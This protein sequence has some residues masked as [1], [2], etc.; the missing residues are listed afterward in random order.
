[1]GSNRDTKQLLDLA[2]CADIVCPV[3][4]LLSANPQ[5]IVEDPFNYAGAFD[6]AGYTTINMLRS[7]GLP[8]VI[9]L[10]QHIEKIEPKHQDKIIKFYK[11]FLTS[12]FNESKS[13]TLQSNNDIVN[14][15]RTL[16]SCGLVAQSWKT[17]RGY[18]LADQAEV[19]A[20]GNVTVFG[21]LKGSCINPNQLVHVTGLDDFQIEKI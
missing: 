8:R 15:F 14:L 17:D 7:L 1:V 19:N 10:I 3:V 4:S 18:I 6:E 13:V 12:E 20:E 21:F 16:D 11:R 2:K 9:G 5:R